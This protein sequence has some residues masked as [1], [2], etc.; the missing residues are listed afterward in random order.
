MAKILNIFVY[1]SR[2]D[3]TSPTKDKLSCLEHWKNVLEKNSNEGGKGI[4]LHAMTS[5]SDWMVSVLTQICFSRQTQFID[6]HCPT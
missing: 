5:N 2:K 4:K 3:S 1:V 6:A